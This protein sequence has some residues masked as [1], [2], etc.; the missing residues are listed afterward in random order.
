MDFLASIPRI[1]FQDFADKFNN[2]MNGEKV[3]DDS[4][5]KH[6]VYEEN[7]D[8]KKSIIIA[9]ATDAKHSNSQGIH[10][11]EIYRDRFGNG[12]EM[13]FSQKVFTSKNFF[14]L[15]DQRTKKNVKIV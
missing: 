10:K 3:S 14:L 8:Y 9:S 15:E 1:N 13:V 7:S 4:F 2:N 6:A 5:L 11:L 12:Q